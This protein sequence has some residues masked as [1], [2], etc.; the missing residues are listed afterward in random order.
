[1]CTVVAGG[2]GGQMEPWAVAVTVLV[3]G[4]GIVLIIII[5]MVVIRKSSK[6]A[7]ESQ[8][9]YVYFIMVICSKDEIHSW[10]RKLRYF[11][12]CMILSVKPCSPQTMFTHWSFLAIS[13][14][15]A[16]VLVQKK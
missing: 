12:Y 3:T 13:G 7:P 11:Q 10:L 8:D 6:T 2:T 1:M 9:E 16:K 14:H 15:I 5:I 4:G